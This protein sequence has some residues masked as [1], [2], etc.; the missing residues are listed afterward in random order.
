MGQL[1]HLEPD[2]QYAVEQGALSLAQ[3]WC[4][5]DEIL[6]S[7]TGV[8]LLPQEWEPLLLRLQ[9]LQTELPPGVRRS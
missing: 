6:L 1:L 5:Q 3:A 8:L 9:L 4:L 7:E 2:L